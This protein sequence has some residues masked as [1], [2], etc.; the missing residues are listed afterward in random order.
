MLRRTTTYFFCIRWR[1]ERNDDTLNLQVPHV[2]CLTLA[3][4]VLSTM[5]YK[6]E[7]VS[8]YSD[9]GYLFEWKVR[10]YCVD[11]KQC[12]YRL[13]AIW[14]FIRARINQH[15]RQHLAKHKENHTELKIH[16][17][18]TQLCSICSWFHMHFVFDLPKCMEWH[19]RNTK[20]AKCLS[21]KKMMRW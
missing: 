15:D 5:Q 7:M 14:C 11:P 3:S 6:I 19:N 4:I 2:E 17:F 18:K 20:S 10:I 12:Y 9:Q 1:T 16:M 13:G 21:E 8:L